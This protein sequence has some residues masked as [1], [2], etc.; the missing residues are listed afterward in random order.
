MLMRVSRLL[1]RAVA[2]AAVSLALN[3]C[4]TTDTSNTS[5]ATDAMP[6][7]DTVVDS[8]PVTE[9]TTDSVVQ[10]DVT[11][12]IDDDPGR[13]EEVSVGADVTITLE[14]PDESDEFHLHG[15]DLDTGPLDPGEP[16]DISFTATKAGEFELESHETGDV[17]MTLVVK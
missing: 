14:N 1:R 16:G 11:V 2:I 13:V 6:S 15:Y 4:A 9:P 7:A 5:P 10:I 3:A 17:L 8:V 12:G